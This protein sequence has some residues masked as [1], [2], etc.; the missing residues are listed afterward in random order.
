MDKTS[1]GF[2]FL[3]Q[4]SWELHTALL[5]TSPW[6]ALTLRAMPSIQGAGKSTYLSE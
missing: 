4:F 1:H 5:Q 2:S 6:A 3:E